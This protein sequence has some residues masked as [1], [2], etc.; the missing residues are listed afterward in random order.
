[1]DKTKELV[2]DFRKKHP[3]V[4]PFYTTVERVQL[5]QEEFLEIHFLRP[6]RS[7]LS[8]TSTQAPL[9][10]LK[11]HISDIRAAVLRPWEER[12][13][14]LRGLLGSCCHLLRA[15][16]NNSAYPGQ[17]A[18]WRAPQTPSIACSPCCPQVDDIIAWGAGRR[19]Y[20]GNFFPTAIRLLSC[21]EIAAI[22]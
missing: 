22:L 12:W 15:W 4:P 17:K 13:G 5:K 18:S 20:C 11:S 6:Q 21:T 19:G 8:P 7:E 9:S 2:I 14:Q 10:V 1:M 16:S 3:T